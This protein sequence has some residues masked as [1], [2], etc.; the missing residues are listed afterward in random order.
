MNTV[1]RKVVKFLMLYLVVRIVASEI[2]RVTSYFY[3]SL[4][5]VK[6]V[7]LFEELFISTIFKCRYVNKKLNQAIRLGYNT[8][9]PFRIAVC[10]VMSLKI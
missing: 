4:E 8:A 9:A 2:W 7:Q 5:T 1:H 3:T 6:I 10:L